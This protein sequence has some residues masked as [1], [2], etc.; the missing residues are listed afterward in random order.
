LVITNRVQVDVELVVDV[1]VDD[2]IVVLAL[3]VQVNCVIETVE[4]NDG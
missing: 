4:D 2:D 3:E 1:Q